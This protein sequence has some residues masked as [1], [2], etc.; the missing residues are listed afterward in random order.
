MS[1]C[2]LI[3][4]S[5]SKRLIFTSAIIFLVFENLSPQRVWYNLDV[6]RLYQIL[7]VYKEWYTCVMGGL[8]VCPRIK[9]L[10]AAPANIT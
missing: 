6:E 2:V 1:F 3:Y 10:Y 8:V 9:S 5:V 4:R 7:Q